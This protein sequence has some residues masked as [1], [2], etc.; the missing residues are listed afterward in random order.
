MILDDF[1]ELLAFFF[2]SRE[3]NPEKNYE[4]PLEFFSNSK[5]K[6]FFL[7][8]LQGRGAIWEVVTSLLE[9]IVELRIVEE[10]GEEGVKKTGEKW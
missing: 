3:E 10:M 1:C 5:P 8:M 9:G 7:A 4:I 6:K 2:I